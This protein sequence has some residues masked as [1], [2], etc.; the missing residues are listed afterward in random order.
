VVPEGLVKEG[1]QPVAVGEEGPVGNE[2]LAEG[3]V[4]RPVGGGCGPAVE[5]VVLEGGMAG[6]AAGL[7]D[8]AMGLDP[9]EGVRGFEDPG[10]DAGDGNGEAMAAVAAA[11]LP[12][13]FIP[14][15][16]LQGE[17]GP[18]DNVVVLRTL[19]Y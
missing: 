4:G 12:G 17:P 3:E 10:E 6:I 16:G 13:A 14:A 7:P 2:G 18:V 15:E 11:V 8:G 1:L 19:V 5:A 9:A